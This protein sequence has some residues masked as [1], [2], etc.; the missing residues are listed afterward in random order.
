M[1]TIQIV[2]DEATLRV[3]DRAAHR[4]KVN[5]SA[6][7]RRA[8]AYYVRRQRIIELEEKQRRGYEENPS[9]EFDAWERVASWPER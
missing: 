1:K 9:H 2:L 8:L 3:A 7:F 4:A 6:L 5:R